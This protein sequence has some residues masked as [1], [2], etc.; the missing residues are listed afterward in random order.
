V[1]PVSFGVSGGSLVVRPA[2][3]LA[4]D[5]FA[6][7]EPVCIAVPITSGESQ[8]KCKKG[9]VEVPNNSGSGGAI[10]AY[11]TYFLKLLNEAMGGLI[12]LVIVIAGIQ[13]ILSAGD[14][15]RVKAAKT[16]LTQ[17]ITALVLYMFMFA[18]LN[19][20]VPGGIL[21]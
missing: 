19:F 13:Y 17:A 9:Q 21:T 20:L 5:P 11:L 6:S 8:G 15:A 3:A 14:P 7:T 4:K 18:I 10:V 12:V 16:R 2:V 1:V